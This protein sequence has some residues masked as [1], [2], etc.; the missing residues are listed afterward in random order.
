MRSRPLQDDRAERAYQA[1]KRR[2]LLKKEVVRAYGG[3]CAHCPEDAPEA[4]ALHHVASD[5][6]SDPMAARPHP[7]PVGSGA[8][9]RGGP[10]VY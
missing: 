6:H 9:K 8:H 5:G 3:K 10:A 7:P 2:R 1:R 4:L